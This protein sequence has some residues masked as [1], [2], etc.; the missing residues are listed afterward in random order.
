MEDQYHEAGPAYLMLR[1]RRN[2]RLFGR[3]A[4]LGRCVE[5]GSGRHAWA[6][7][8]LLRGAVRSDMSASTHVLVQAVH[9]GHRMAWG[10]FGRL[11]FCSI[12]CEV[13]AGRR[14]ASFVAVAWQ[15]N[16]LLKPL[17][18]HKGI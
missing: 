1:V 2:L 14:R 17:C 3:I 18:T 12:V 10:E 13:P 4:C 16:L 5:M 7:D 8:V 15:A 6:G 11:T 9:S